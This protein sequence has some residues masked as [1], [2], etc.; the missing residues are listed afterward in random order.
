MTHEA[1]CQK[2][3]R[4]LNPHRNQ[5]YENLVVHEPVRRV[6]NNVPR[7]EFSFDGLL[8][9]LTA[10]FRQTLFPS[11]EF[12]LIKRYSDPAP[13]TEGE[14]NYAYEDLVEKRKQDVT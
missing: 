1:L 14:E 3:P 4:F 2:D 10:P 11:R 13:D 5:F 8:S 6:P 12:P 7:F 9:S